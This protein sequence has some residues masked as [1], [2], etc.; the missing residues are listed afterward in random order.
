VGPGQRK[1][2]RI[3]SGIGLSSTPPLYRTESGSFKGRVALT[4]KQAARSLKDDQGQEQNVLPRR[5]PPALSSRLT[6]APRGR[7]TGR[8]ASFIYFEEEPGGL[9]ARSWSATA[10]AKE[11][12]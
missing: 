7:R 11:L 6:L 4:L 3:G 5:F 10:L 12:R 9:S 2:V 1:R 8:R